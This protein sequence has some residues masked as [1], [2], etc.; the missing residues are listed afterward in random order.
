MTLFKQLY[1][2]GIVFDVD[3]YAAGNQ[4]DDPE[5]PSD[6]DLLDTFIYLWDNFPNI[7][8]LQGFKFF[9]YSN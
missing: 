1:K 2:E 9:G 4:T 8:L 6:I 3:Y 5:M 7:R